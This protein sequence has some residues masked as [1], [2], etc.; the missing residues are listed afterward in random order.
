MLTADENNSY[1]EVVE[2]VSFLSLYVN[3][4]EKHLKFSFRTLETNT[5]K[6]R[7]QTWVIQTQADSH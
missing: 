3:S 4:L 2:N 5:E 1:L 6:A 7:K